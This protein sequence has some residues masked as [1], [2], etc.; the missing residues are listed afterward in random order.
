M[1]IFHCCVQKTAS[2]WIASIFADSRVKE[3]SGLPTYNYSAWFLEQFGPHK[4]TDISFPPNAIPNNTIVTPLYIDFEKFLT[5]PKTDNYKT[6]FVA[7]DPRDIVVS[8]YFSIKYSHPVIADLINELRHTLKQLSV[9]EGIVFSIQTLNNLHLFQ[10]LRSWHNAPQVDGNVL[11]TSFEELTS[12]NNFEAFER[13]FKHCQIPIDSSLLH[14][15]LEDHKFE[16]LFNRNKGEEDHFSH[17]RKGIQGDWINF[18]AP[19]LEKI[20][21]DTVGD[22]PSLFGYRTKD[23]IVQSWL[24]NLKDQNRVLKQELSESKSHCYQVQATLEEV[25]AEGHHY[26]SKLKN[27]EADRQKL[28]VQLAEIQSQL[29]QTQ[30]QYQKLQAQFWDVQQ[31]RTKLEGQFQIELAKAQSRAQKLQAKLNQVRDRS[32][33]RQQNLRTQLEQTQAMLQALQSSKFWKLRTLWFRFRK[34]VG[35]GDS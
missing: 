33:K 18:F 14:Q 11:L 31:L 6:F 10:A 19:D 25:Q 35:I 28:Y 30:A 7:R 29:T 5:I 16:K 13:L 22:L 4:L 23:E 32:Q 20:F 1:N 34:F 9:H 2:Q 27:L 15:V 26:Q 21:Q 8:W 24:H 17:Y 12:S 3:A